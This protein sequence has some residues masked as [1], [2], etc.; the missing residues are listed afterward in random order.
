MDS[1]ADNC[2]GGGGVVAALVGD[3]SK[4]AIY[5]YPVPLVKSSTMESRTGDTPEYL[6][7]RTT[8]ELV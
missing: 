2:G 5:S 7:S 8:L 6:R 1:V 3:G 4:E